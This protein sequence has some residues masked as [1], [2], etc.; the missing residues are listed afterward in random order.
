MYCYFEA[1]TGRIFRTAPSAPSNYFRYTFD[2]RHLRRLGLIVARATPTLHG[3]EY[4]PSDLAWVEGNHIDRPGGL[5]P[6][7]I[8]PNRERR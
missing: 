3:L 6:R 7:P 8:D 5:I 4:T 2:R 1:Q